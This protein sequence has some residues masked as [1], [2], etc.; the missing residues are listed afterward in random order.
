MS[1]VVGCIDFLHQQ[2]TSD[3][4]KHL[5]DHVL[6][7]AQNFVVTFVRAVFFSRRE[8]PELGLAPL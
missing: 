2:L 5:S 6:P 1:R 8:A 7:I 3:P 4:P